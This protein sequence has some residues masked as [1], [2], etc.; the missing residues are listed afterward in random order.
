MS[1]KFSSFYASSKPE[2][3]KQNADSMRRAKQASEDRR[4]FFDAV[5]NALPHNVE[6][7]Y[8]ALPSRIRHQ[9]SLA[10]FKRKVANF[11]G[12]SVESL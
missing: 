12:V 1:R 4:T 3:P 11:Q 8:N 7:T 10:T 9:S 6:E 5:H 2:T